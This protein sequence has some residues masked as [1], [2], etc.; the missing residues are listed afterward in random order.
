MNWLT[1]VLFGQ[2]LKGLIASTMLDDEP[3][4]F[5]ES[6]TEALNA[7]TRYTIIVTVLYGKQEMSDNTMLYIMVTTCGF[8]HL[9]IH[10]FIYS[11]IHSF[12][13]PFIQRLIQVRGQKDMDSPLQGSHTSY[14][15]NLATSRTT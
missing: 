9:F 13:H 4:K 8:I 3:G 14:Y 7:L 15:G 5:A 2:V 10:P 11:S 12:I 1:F 6:R